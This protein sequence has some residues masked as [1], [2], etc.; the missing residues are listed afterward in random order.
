MNGNMVPVTNSFCSLTSR[1]SSNSYI[2]L[3]SGFSQRIPQRGRKM[4]N[5]KIQKYKRQVH[6]TSV[7]TQKDYHPLCAI[8]LCWENTTHLFHSF[9]E[10]RAHFHVYSSEKKHEQNKGHVLSARMPRN[11][12]SKSYLKR[13]FVS[14]CSLA[15]HY[16]PLQ[17][18][19][20]MEVRQ[21]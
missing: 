1:V 20:H 13:D 7:F 8:P 11:W 3:S 9:R 17:S 10:K 18:V 14:R 15:I 19:V 6:S 2:F 5:V 21:V 12:Y 4:W 16:C